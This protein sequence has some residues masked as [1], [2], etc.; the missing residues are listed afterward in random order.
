MPAH[1]MSWYRIVAYNCSTDPPSEDSLIQEFFTKFSF[2]GST[3]GLHDRYVWMG[4]LRHNTYC[5]FASICM[6]CLRLPASQSYNGMLSSSGCRSACP[7]FTA[8]KH[9]CLVWS[10]NSQ[11]SPYFSGTIAYHGTTEIWHSR[12]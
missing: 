2:E 1:E 4:I 6:T 7:A 3:D 11:V 5:H 10:S 9:V 12:H 8:Y